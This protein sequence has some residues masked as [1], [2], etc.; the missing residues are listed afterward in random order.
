MTRGLATEAASYAGDLNLESAGRQL[1]VPALRQAAVPGPGLVPTTPVPLDYRADNPWD[2][3]YLG[4]AIE[5]GDELQARSQGFTAQLAPGEGHTAGFYRQLLPDL[6][7]E[8]AFD[9]GLIDPGIP[10]GDTLVGAAIAAESRRGAFGDRWRGVFSFRAQ[11]ARWGLVALEQRVTRAPL[12][13]TVDAALGRL[14]T[15]AATLAAGAPGTAGGALGALTGPVATAP[16]GTSAPGGGPTTPGGTGGPR[17]TTTTL[18]P[19]PPSGLLP[20]ILPAPPSG[21]TT[22]TSTPGPAGGLVDNVGNA[23]GGLLGGLLGG[24]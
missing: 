12:L 8:R 21:P 7:G 10:P 3:R 1:T 13:S 16:N 15:G 2:R 11:G 6:E 5:L 20:P 17:A 9:Q 19:P 23:V 22:T 14:G 4:D 18:L 24:H